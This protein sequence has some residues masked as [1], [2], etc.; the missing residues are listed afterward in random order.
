MQVET[1]C[2]FLME[3]FVISSFHR[4]LCSCDLSLMWINLPSIYLTFKPEI[5][6]GGSKMADFR[7]LRHTTL[8]QQNF[9]SCR[10]SWELYVRRK[11]ILTFIVITNTT[12]RLT[13]PHS[14]TPNKDGGIMNR[15]VSF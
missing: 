9:S 15:G 3:F 8:R 11:V 5:Q 4:Q 1:N 12:T 2:V 7:L 10:A 14:P 13:T 6:D